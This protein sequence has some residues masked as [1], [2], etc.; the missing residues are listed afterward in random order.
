M[1]WVYMKKLQHRRAI[2]FVWLLLAAP[3]LAAQ[4]PTTRVE[5]IEQERRHKI[6]VLW[7]E[8]ES[9][10]VA[11]ANRLVQRGLVAG[12]ESG[13]G[14][15]GVQFTVGGMR[16]GQG[17]SF[18]IGYRRTDLWRER[19]DFRT[20]ARGTVWGGYMF[21][22]SL[23]L[24]GLRIGRTLVGLYAKLE[25]SPHMDYYGPG[26]SSK[27]GDRTSYLLTDLAVDANAGVRLLGPIKVGLTGGFLFSHTGSPRT[28]NNPSTGDVFGPSEAAGFGEDTDFARWGGLLALDYRDNP[29][30]PKAGGV[31]G[32]R[33]R[34]YS[35]RTQGQYGFRQVDIEFQQYIPY[36][37][38][39][40]VVAFR[41]AAV[42]SFANTG[43]QVPFYL[44]P[45]LG[46]NDDL[47]GY[48]RY[49]FTDNQVIYMGLEHRWYVFSG[50]DMAVFLDAGK[51]VSKT[52]DFDFTDLKYSG[53]VGFRAKVWNAVFMRIDF[54]ASPEDFRL[55]WTFSDIFK[56]KF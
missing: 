11:T 5:Q 39:T 25:S 3:P 27:K 38:K 16:S 26:F 2:L 46:G 14:V 21:D 28:T 50:L 47:R 9:P 6:A 40:R 45:T 10:L 7:P 53:G 54:A 15:N 24:K 44:Q 23:D 19:L 4:E 30:G 36:F 29:A 43:K 35:D 41:W 13:R 42:L 31:L 32:G 49:R 1:E 8:H 12:F 55:I 37:N 51:A 56:A 33:F 48:A 17:T 34:Q 52:A 18:G 20:T 22:G